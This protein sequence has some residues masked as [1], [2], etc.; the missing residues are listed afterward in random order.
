MKIG[1]VLD[2]SLDKTDGVQ[3]YVLTLGRWLVKN[4]HE[5]HYLVG[6]TKRSDLPNVHS[7]SRNIAVRFNQNRMSMPIGGNSRAIRA[8]LER[9]QFDILHVQVPYSPLLAA[10]VIRLAPTRTAIVGTFHVIPYS[11]I[12]SIASSLLATWLKKS[13]SRFDLMLSVSEPASDFAA[14]A[15]GLHSKILP[16][17]IDYSSM[18]IGRVKFLDDNSFHIVFLGRLV[19]R[20]GVWQ[21]LRAL[22]YMQQNSDLSKNLRVTIA[23]SGHLM[24][25][26]KNYCE[27]TGLECV[28]FIGHIPEKDKAGLLKSADIAVY[29][30]LGGESFG[31]VLIEAMTAGAGVVLGGNNSG[32]SS[33]LN[34]WPE[35][36]IDPND[37]QQLAKSLQLFI[38]DKALR[39]RI[40][41]LQHKA[42]QSYD[43]NKV[44]L[45]LVSLYESTIANKR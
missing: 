20:K 36:L 39:E 12:Q 10:R 5:V 28:K 33:V 42:V 15:Y 27:A 22:N 19:P 6:E 3:Q 40:G 11:A 44:G 9:K 37:T 18:R 35:T 2:D 43:V 16:N 25:R 17:V 41:E 1:F 8:L 21:L 4:G 7:L 34:K 29:P 14:S 32:Y 38:N 24:P 31:I 30:S 26:L 45:K 23:G 13:L